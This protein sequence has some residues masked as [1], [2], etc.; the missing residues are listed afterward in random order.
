MADEVERGLTRVLRQLGEANAD[1][2]KTAAEVRG[3]VELLVEKGVVTAAEVAAK[4]GQAGQPLDAAQ[5][6]RLYLINDDQRDKYGD[7]INADVDCASRYSLCQAACC[8]FQVPLS[9]QD[10]D[11]GA[12]RWD[13]GRPFYLRKD[14]TDRR[15]VYQDRATNGCGNYAARPLACRTYSCKSDSRIWRDFEGRVV[16]AKGIAALLAQEGHRPLDLIAPSPTL[17]SLVRSED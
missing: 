8:T 17:P 13:L 7:L 4:L 5:R 12:S 14:A 1:L 11:E 16:N 3:M 6:R 10:L 15:C 9:E 2:Q